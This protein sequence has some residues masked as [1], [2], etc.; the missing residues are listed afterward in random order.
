MLAR[1]GGEGGIGFDAPGPTNHGRPTP[2]W[3]TCCN[4]IRNNLSRGRSVSKM[5]LAVFQENPT[6]K[7][8]GSS[9]KGTRVSRVVRPSS[10][11]DRNLLVLEARFFDG[12][13]GGALGKD[14]RTSGSTAQFSILACLAAS[15]THC[16]R[17]TFPWVG[18]Y[19]HT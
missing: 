15:G 16:S 17:C 8:R 19:N 10:A 6:D 1:V 5:Q 14:E 18:T 4:K 12:M 9:P 13:N 2:P 3:P 7:T 11:E